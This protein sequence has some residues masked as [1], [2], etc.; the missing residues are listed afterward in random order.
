MDPRHFHA[1]QGDDEAA[2]E[3]LGEVQDPAGELILPPGGGGLGV[4]EEDD[5][6]A[7]APPV[8][9]ELVEGRAEPAAGGDGEAL[10]RGGVELREL[11]RLPPLDE[12]GRREVGDQAHAGKPLY[13]DGVAQLR[14]AEE[15]HMDGHGAK[16]KYTVRVKTFESMSFELRDRDLLGRIGRL[17][18]KSGVVETPALLP[19]VNPLSQP[20]P[21]RRMME[22][23]RCRVLITNA[24]LIKKHFGDADLEVHR[25]LDYDGVVATDSGAYQIL[26]YGGVDADPGEIVEFQRRIGSDIA[27]ILDVPT[28]WDVPRS[29]A[30]WTVEETLRRARAALPLI[31]GDDALWV[32]P[33]QGGGY[34][35]LVERSAR[36]IGSMPFQVHALGSPTQVMERYLFNVLVDMIMAAKLNLPPDRPLHLFGA[37]HPM[38]FSLAVALGCD[39]FDSAAYAL[40]AREGRYMT[41]LGTMR[42][43][44]LSYLPCSC[45]VC[46]RHDAAEL[47]E[48]LKGERIRALT[49]HNLYVSMAEMDTI[50][51][52]ISEGSL[53]ELLEARSRAHPALASALK[54]LRRYRDAL[55]RGN[56]AYKRRGVFIFDSTSLARPEVTRHI[57]RLET[58]YRAPGDAERL[59]LASAP[60]AKPFA[61]APGYRRLRRAVEKALGYAASGV[62]VCFYTAPFGVIPAELSETYPLSQFEA[63][64]PLDRETLNFAAEQVGRYV[65]ASSYSQAI[66]LRGAGDLDELVEARCRDACQRTGRPLTV[67]SD[68]RPWGD[69]AMR[70][71]VEALKG[72]RA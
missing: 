13:Q 34:L 12:L 64:H 4:A 69:E 24:Y 27:V 38:M 16:M 66:L 60:E 68:P 45:P 8:G 62:H 40:Y 39:M 49:E 43:S 54:H 70:R 17:K 31:E 18:T 35:D 7:A 2:A 14:L 41:P 32:G 58:H 48:M 22:E 15:P 5:G 59:L 25:L 52:A 29:R 26:V 46:R 47:R 37:G 6:V 72:P 36:A 3:A 55:E 20:I 33:V 63:V 57:R 56:P 10:E 44:G 65:E 61:R 53:W 71:L 42:L 19:V 21:P 23:F 51:Q 67:V 1:S 9:V 11:L 30:E 50:K 28:G